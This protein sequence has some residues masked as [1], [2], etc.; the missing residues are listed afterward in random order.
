MGVA[1]GGRIGLV[2]A[3][4]AAGGASC[5]QPGPPLYAAF[6]RFCASTGADPAAV[7][8]RV[9]QAGGR[10]GQDASTSTPFPM[11]MR[12][13]TL[14]DLQ[15]GSGTA[16][17]PSSKGVTQAWTC[18]VV[19]FK[20]DPASFDAIRRWAGVAADGSTDDPVVYYSFEVTNG[21]HAPPP[22]DPAALARDD[23]AGR[24]WNLT[25]MRTPDGGQL[26]LLR[27]RPPGGG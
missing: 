9:E 7:K 8:A 13:W 23:A 16:D 2:I 25:V 3:L 4:C 26:Q 5:A 1:A 14:K 12:T 15:I 20:P 11:S 24:V 17:A 6:V 22:S 27:S 10:L 19:S 18:N 21:A